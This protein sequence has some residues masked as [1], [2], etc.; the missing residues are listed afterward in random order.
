MAFAANNLKT[1]LAAWSY[2]MVNLQYRG[3]T[4]LSVAA[5]D[6]LIMLYNN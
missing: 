3:K 6:W 1:S 5:N 4:K 2:A